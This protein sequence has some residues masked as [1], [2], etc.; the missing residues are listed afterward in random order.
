[1]HNFEL[2]DL[3]TQKE[4][5]WKEDKVV[6]CVDEPFNEEWSIPLA[7]I[8]A[9]VILEPSILEFNLLLFNLVRLSNSTNELF[10]EEQSLQLKFFKTQLQLKN[11]P[12]TDVRFKRIASFSS[13][14]IE[15]I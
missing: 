4:A 9:V 5:S 7:I 2:D 8:V 6:V 12:S 13:D 1:V 3:H 10:L 11:L 14:S 15:G